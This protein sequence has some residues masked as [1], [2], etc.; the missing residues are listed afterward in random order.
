MKGFF[1]S[2]KFK[3]LVCIVVIVA[4]IMTYAAANGR[5]SAAPQEILSVIMV[6]FQRIGA[7]L[8]NGVSGISKKL[9]DIDKVI[10]ENEQLKEEIA[11][12][13]NQMVDY[14]TIKAENDMFRETLRIQEENITYTQISASVIGRD[15]LDKFYSFTIDKGSSSGIEV[16]DVVYCADGLV[17]KVIETAPNYSKVITILDPRVNIGCSVSRTR[18]IG[19]ATGDAALAAQGKLILN[20]LP[21]ETLVAQNDLVV[22]TGYGGVFPKG[23]IVG[24][25]E[26]VLPEASGKS[27]YAVVQPTADV[28]N[29][30]MVFII[31]DFTA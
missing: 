18:D 19:T 27:N 6:P 1:E 29:I 16:E 22:T 20:Y 28:K 4:G 8:E 5:L 21:K 14:D 17:G 24:T 12:M 3:V 7:M 31:T 2:K 11:E 23:L 30:T 10:E 26:D 9:S 25:V 13:R 15:T